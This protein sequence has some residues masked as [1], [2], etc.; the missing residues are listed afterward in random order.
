MKRRLL[1]VSPHFPPVNAPDMQ[2]VRQSLPAFVA[3]GWEVTV[4][5]VDDP[6]PSAPVEPELLATLPPE[7]RV[8]RVR[9]CSRRWTGLLG[10]GNVALRALPFLFQRG[11]RLLATQRYDAMYFSTTMFIVLPFARLWRAWYGVPA[12][13]DFQDP[14]VS[15]FYSR[16]GA[17]RPP[18]GWKY[19]LV[20]ALNRRL[21]GWSLRGVAHL[22]AVSS[23]YVTALRERHAFLR[24]TPAT[25]LPFGFPDADLALARERHRDAPMRSNAGLRLAFAGA[26]SPG[27]LPAVEIFLAGASVARRAGLPVA[28][29]F[30]GTSYAARDAAKNVTAD[31]VEKY[32]LQ[33]AVCEQP[34]RLPY[35]AAMEK[36]FETDAGLLFGSTELSFLP[37]KLLSVLAAG[38]PVL[39]VAPTGSAMIARLKQFGQSCVTFAPDA[40]T[41]SDAAVQSVKNFLQKLATGQ[42]PPPDHARLAGFSATDLAQR[43]LEIFASVAP[44]A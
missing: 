43:Q 21:E 9:C 32:G 20:H 19:G 38:R 11:C 23:D 2:R 27:M 28:V 13:I 22:I 31:L 39:A 26:I 34:A 30:F 15:D 33:D 24:D 10:V 1:I 25:V 5:T 42:A 14:W 44:D 16:P 17:P 4:L 6:T 8:E 18:G 12:V 7:V 35:F 3:A 29:E 36:L 41:A 37:S 40:T